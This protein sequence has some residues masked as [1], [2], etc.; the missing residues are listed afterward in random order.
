MVMCGLSNRIIEK[1]AKQAVK[2]NHKS[3]NVGAPELL[4]M[5]VLLTV[6]VLA[7]VAF[8]RRK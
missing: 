2:P 6:P 3:V 1:K 4:I 7:V 5:L 8:V